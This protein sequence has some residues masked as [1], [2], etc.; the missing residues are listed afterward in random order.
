MQ[1]GVLFQIPIYV[2]NFAVRMIWTKFQVVI[3]RKDENTDSGDSSCFLDTNALQR[4]P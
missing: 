2:A 3:T 1:L 4:V